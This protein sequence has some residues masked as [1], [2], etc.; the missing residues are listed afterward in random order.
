MKLIN[1]NFT[2]YK[3]IID[4]GNADIKDFTVLV[5][6][7]E[8]GK[9]NILKALYKFNNTMNEQFTKLRDYPRSIYHEY[10]ENHPVVRVIFQLTDEEK[11]ELQEQFEITG[12]SYIHFTRKYNYTFFLFKLR[13]I[14]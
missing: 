7:N 6:K 13:C 12:V 1:L 5:G 9:T 10:D 2:K 4:S 8:S 3:S 11:K 14:N